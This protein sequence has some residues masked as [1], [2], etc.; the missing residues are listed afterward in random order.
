MPPLFR[1]EIFPPFSEFVA[2]LRWKIFEPMSF[3]PKGSS[4][5]RGQLAEPFKTLSNPLPFFWWKVFPSLEPFSHALS[6]IRIQ[7]CPAPGPFT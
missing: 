1:F 7:G 2:A 6:L 4:F 5:F 3:F